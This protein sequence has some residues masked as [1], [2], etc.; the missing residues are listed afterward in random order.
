M[1]ELGDALAKVKKTD[2]STTTFAKAEK[3]TEEIKEDA[4]RGYALLTLGRK[5]KSA[6]RADGARKVLVKADEVANQIKDSSIKGPLLADIQAA[7][8]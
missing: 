3:I 7:L 1:A 4:A 6:G 8:K 5:M 2:E